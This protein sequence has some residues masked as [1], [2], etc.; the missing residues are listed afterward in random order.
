M[1]YQQMT[2]QFQSQILSK[3]IFPILIFIIPTFNFLD[4]KITCGQNHKDPDN[5]CIQNILVPSPFKE[6]NFI[7]IYMCIVKFLKKV[8]YLIY[9][10]LPNVLHCKPLQSKNISFY[11]KSTLSSWC[12]QIRNLF[13]LTIMQN[14][15]KLVKK[16][17]LLTGF[18]LS[19]QLTRA[20]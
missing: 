3:F 16:K 13:L 10:P 11:Y 17:Y 7:Y 1:T 9:T 5:P 4:C 15:L 12:F 18:A 6:N 8:C 20:R 14:K 2:F 19:Y